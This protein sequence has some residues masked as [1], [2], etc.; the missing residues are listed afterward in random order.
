MRPTAAPIQLP[1]RDRLFL[2]ASQAIN[3]AFFG[4]DPD[5]SLSARSF[6][7]GRSDPVWARRR[8][9]ID[10]VLGFNHCARVYQAQL[11]RESAR[12]Q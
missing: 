6:R 9:R 1:L 11:Q 7:M 12:A 2:L 8:D 10:R 4:G 3:T 5:E